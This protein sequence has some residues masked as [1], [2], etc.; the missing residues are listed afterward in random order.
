MMP[1]KQNGSEEPLRESLKVP[2][3]IFAL[4]AYPAV[5]NTGQ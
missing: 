3:G 1:S 5:K 2:S 4:V